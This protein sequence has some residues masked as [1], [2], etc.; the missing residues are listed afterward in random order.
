MKHSG[1]RSRSLNPTHHQ[2]VSSLKAFFP[3]S[4][5]K[6]GG[7][8]LKLTKPEI[9]MKKLLAIG[10]ATAAIAFFPLAKPARAEW[11]ESE[12]VHVIDGLNSLWDLWSRES[13]V[14]YRP[15]VVYT[16]AEAEDT[17]CGEV[18]IAHY[19]PENNTIHLEMGAMSQ[20]AYE[21]GDS[22]AYVVLAHEYGHSVQRHLG[23]FNQRIPTRDLEL[24]ADCFAGTFFALAEYVGALETGDLEEGMFSAFN[25]GDYD[26]WHA[27]HHGTPRQRMA[28]FTL[29]Y[30]NPKACF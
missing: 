13:G 8:V 12:L 27:S 3:Q 26:F 4:L 7:I 9:K 5:A 29:G 30:K 25:S 14:P 11:T 24:Q 22:A 6:L 18:H 21:I 10:L 1:L 16:H 20:L 2:P 23:L 15:P 28:A 19:C 17:F